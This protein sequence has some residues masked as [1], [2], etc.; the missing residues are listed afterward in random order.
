MHEHY[1]FRPLQQHT[2]HS[3]NPDGGE[4][5][6]YLLAREADQVA[7]FLRRVYRGYPWMHDVGRVAEELRGWNDGGT[8]RRMGGY[9][10]GRGLGYGVW[11][12]RGS[13]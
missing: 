6:A 5:E 8:G 12:R 3:H 2:P 13:W 7:R 4:L 1:K 9:A 11:D 10:G